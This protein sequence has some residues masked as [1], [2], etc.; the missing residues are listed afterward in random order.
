[1]AELRRSAETNERM[2]YAS[3]DLRVREA[4]SDARRE[5]E[6]AQAQQHEKQ[7][8]RLERGMSADTLQPMAP[9]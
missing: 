1:M 6:A 3:A 9:A 8:A 2:A 5:W 4:L 7:A